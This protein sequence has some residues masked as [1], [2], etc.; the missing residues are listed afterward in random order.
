MKNLGFFGA[1]NMG[2]ALLQG[3]RG[4]ELA[5]GAYDINPQALQRAADLGA[6]AFSSAEDLVCWA[7]M[8][9]CCVKPQYLDGLLQMLADGAKG[10]PVAS[11]VAGL[12]TG[13]LHRAFPGSRV[14]RVMPNTPALVGQ[15]MIALS[16]DTDL[17]PEEKGVFEAAF[18]CVGRVVWVQEG[19]MDAVTAV[20]GSGPAY[21]YLLIEAMTEAGVREGLAFD[22]AKQ[23]AA[24]TVLGTAQMVLQCETHPA[25]LRAQV[26]SPAGTTAEALY[27]LEKA[28]FKAGVMDA[29][30]A[31]AQRSRQLG[32]H[33]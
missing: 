24:Q 26:T 11:I 12:S 3:L 20:S 28:G 13:A 17:L 4:G 19:Q 9:V 32:G 25:Q 18:G 8:L 2:L 10:K 7:D 31:C 27:Q 33:K 21:V 15:G 23:L 1:G 16:L 29:V 30:H 14:L 22:V 6:R 5:L